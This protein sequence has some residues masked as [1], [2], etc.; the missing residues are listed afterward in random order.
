M[1]TVR[2]FGVCGGGTGLN[3]GQIW[4]RAGTGGENPEVKVMRLQES[5][6]NVDG[7]GDVVKWVEGKVRAGN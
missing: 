2:R 6:E 4:G 1:A 5:I 7:E 3:V